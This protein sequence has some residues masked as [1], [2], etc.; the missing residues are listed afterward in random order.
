MKRTLRVLGHVLLTVL[1]LWLL[2]WRWNR[3]AVRVYDAPPLQ[4][5]RW[6]P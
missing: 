5:G 3:E 2:A 4:V 1:F 6:R